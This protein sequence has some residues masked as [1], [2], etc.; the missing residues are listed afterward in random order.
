M[1]EAAE[2]LEFERAAQLRDRIDDL[3]RKLS[4]GDEKNPVGSEDK[5]GFAACGRKER[6]RG[7]GRG[8]VIETEE[9]NAPAEECRDRNVGMCN[10]SKCA[11]ED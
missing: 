4:A 9:A 2:N 10:N 6:G 1:L 11:S 8:N 5:P 7:R 3:K